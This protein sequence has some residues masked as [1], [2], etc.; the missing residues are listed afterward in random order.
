[1]P[2]CPREV[3]LSTSRRALLA[4]AHARGMRK[5]PPKKRRV[6]PPKKRSCAYMEARAG[7]V[8]ERAT[9]E[10]HP[11]LCFPLHCAPAPTSADLATMQARGRAGRLQCRPGPACGREA[12]LRRLLSAPTEG[13]EGKVWQQLC[14]RAMGARAPGPGEARA[15]RGQ[16]GLREGQARTWARPTSGHAAAPAP[17]FATRQSAP[18]RRNRAGSPLNDPPASQ[19]ASGQSAAEP[20]R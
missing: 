10:W 12:G 18:E 13:V 1:M 11:R 19:F 20:S 14:G 3:S 15:C 5:P 7:T 8:S 16:A 17:Q 9:A 6:P 4:C 2:R